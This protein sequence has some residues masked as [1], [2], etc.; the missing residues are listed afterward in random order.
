T[1]AAAVCTYGAGNGP[2]GSSA[3]RAGNAKAFPISSRARAGAR[4]TA[5]RG[6][7][8]A[9]A[10]PWERCCRSLRVATGR[11][12]DAEDAERA[13]PPDDGASD[14]VQRLLQPGRTHILP[15]HDVER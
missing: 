3:A 4:V 5:R 7:G 10:S 12:R 8:G 11:K 9:S 14:R 2:H 15:E 6:E 1:S 13:R